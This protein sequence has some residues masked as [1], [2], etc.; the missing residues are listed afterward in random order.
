ML[1]ED[2]Q[3]P[4]IQSLYKL[5]STLHQ[6]SCLSGLDVGTFIAPF[7]A[8]IQ[9]DDTTGPVTGRA[10]AALDKFLAYGLIGTWAGVCVCVAWCVCGQVCVCVCVWA[11]VGVSVWASVCVGCVWA[12]VGVSVW[13]S[14][15]VG[16]SVSI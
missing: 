7:C 8:I 1:Q 2:N 13:A 11:C 5:Q 9:S 6:T 4:L 12:C 14:V 10:I 16:E 3:D 15:C